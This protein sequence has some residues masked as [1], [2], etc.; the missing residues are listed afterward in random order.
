MSAIVFEGWRDITGAVR[1]ALGWRMDERTVRRYADTRRDDR[2][3]TGTRG[4]GVVFLELAALK[5]WAERW[6][7]AVGRV[8]ERRGDRRKRPIV[9]NTDQDCPR[10]TP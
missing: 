2:L 6:K 7:G 5:A 9:S 3:P 4:N 1:K 10:E 8:R